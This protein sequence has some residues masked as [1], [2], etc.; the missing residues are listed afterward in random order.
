MKKITVSDLC[1]ILQLDSSIRE[2]L[3]KN[4]DT[5]RDN[6]K[7]Q[8]LKILWDGVHELENKLAEVKY[9]Q[10][11]LDVDEGKRELTNNLYQEAVKAVWQDFEN[12]LT[13][14]IKEE[15]LIA[16]IRNELKPLIQS[17]DKSN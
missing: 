15:T 8:V 4:F 1:R 12:N 2:D 6:I 10:L 11:L 13:G 14:K 9:E 7:D 5:Y 3:E 17:S 16:D